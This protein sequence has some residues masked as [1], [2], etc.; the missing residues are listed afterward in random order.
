MPTAPGR[1]IAQD[2]DV[3]T[4]EELQHV[5]CGVLALEVTVC[6]DTGLVGGTKHCEA[7]MGSHV[8]LHQTHN[9]GIVKHHGGYKGL[10]CSSVPTHNLEGL[11]WLDKQNVSHHYFFTA[12]RFGLR[13]SQLLS[14]NNNW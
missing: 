5:R 3:F 13:P 9:V 10:K 14:K 2:S 1:S 8:G 12:P 6:P 11:K 4:A 7:I